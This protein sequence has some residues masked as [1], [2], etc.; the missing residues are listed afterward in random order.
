VA[1]TV[2]N[3]NVGYIRLGSFVLVAGSL[4]L[5]PT[6]ASV[7]TTLQLSLPVASN[8]SS[9]TQL[10]GAAHRSSASLAPLSAAI[11]G[12]AATDRAQISFLNDTSVA[13]AVW[14]FW[15]VYLVV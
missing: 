10:S 11:V 5:D 1:A 15:F 14:S 13:N 7:A 3:A 8:M 9:Y 2:T 4:E 6:S 12:D